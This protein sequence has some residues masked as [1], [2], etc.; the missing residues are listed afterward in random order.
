MWTVR[1]IQDDI[2]IEHHKGFVTAEYEPLWLLCEGGTEREARDAL[3][4]EIWAAVARIYEGEVRNSYYPMR[5]PPT[6][7][8]VMD[9]I[10]S[11][12]WETHTPK[13]RYKDE[14]AGVIYLEV[15]M[16]ND[17]LYRRD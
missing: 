17:L 16:D 3:M 14:K 15:E 9:S 6:I 12:Y 2:I 7:K 4:L 13:T 10:V 1:S 11:T 8:E 5:T